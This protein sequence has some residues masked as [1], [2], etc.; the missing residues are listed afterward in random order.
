LFVVQ[1]VISPFITLKK[2]QQRVKNGIKHVLNVVMCRSYTIPFLSWSW[3]FIYHLFSW[4][5]MKWS[6]FFFLF[7][8]EIGLCKKMLESTT[9]AEHEGNLFCKQCYA[10]KFVSVCS[11]FYFSKKKKE[12]LKYRVRKV[13]VSDKELVH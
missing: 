8:L 5:F 4:L 1:N 12:F 6:D 2:Y 10:R 11:I 13:L 7:F 3:L 9:V